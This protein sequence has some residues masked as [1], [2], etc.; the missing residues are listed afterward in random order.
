MKR[1][2]KQIY[3]AI[4]LT[5]MARMPKFD[6]NHNCLLAILHKFRRKFSVIRNNSLELRFDNF[7]R[8]SPLAQS[9]SQFSSADVL[10]YFTFSFMVSKIFKSQLQDIEDEAFYNLTQLQKL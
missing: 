1:L 5:G 3:N 6:Y 7:S 10:L 8:Y 2:I 4:S 9:L